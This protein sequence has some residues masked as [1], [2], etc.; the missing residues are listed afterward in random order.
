M[1]PFVAGKA[2][3]TGD[4]KAKLFY[5]AIISQRSFF[6]ILRI[7]AYVI[8]RKAIAKFQWYYY[9]VLSTGDACTFAV[10]PVERTCQAAIQKAE[11][12]TDVGVLVF[13]PGDSGI[14]SAPVAA[15]GNGRPVQ[16]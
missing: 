5:P 16:N 4:G 6:S 12:H 9:V 14:W 15:G 1:Q 8:C 11:V 3:V 7:R 13:H 2:H 10:E